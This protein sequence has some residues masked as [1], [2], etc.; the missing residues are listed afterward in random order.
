MTE[1]TG[2]H[3]RIK[4]QE[5][6]LGPEANGATVEEIIDAAAA[7]LLVLQERLP[8]DENRKAI[9]Q[10]YSARSALEARTRRRVRQYVL[11]T[12]ETHVSKD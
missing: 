3:F 10:L 5:G 7:R 8:C 6:P 1:T 11:G 4:W 9:D 12:E 2:P